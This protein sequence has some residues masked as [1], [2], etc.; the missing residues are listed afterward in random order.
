MTLTRKR[1]GSAGGIRRGGGRIGEE[2]VK[3][4][5]IKVADRPKVIHR[6]VSKS[7]RT[8]SILHKHWYYVAR[9]YLRAVMMCTV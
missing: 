8:L 2:K 1:P 7:T 4:N 9:V 3:R 6:Q 5:G